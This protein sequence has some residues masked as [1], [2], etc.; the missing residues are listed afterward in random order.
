MVCYS[1]TKECDTLTEEQIDNCVCN[2]EDVGCTARPIK[3]E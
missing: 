1:W 2:G 3:E